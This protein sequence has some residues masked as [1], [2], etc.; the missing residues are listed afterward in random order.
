MLR[1]SNP[2]AVLSTVLLGS[3]VEGWHFVMI[4]VVFTRLVALNLINAIL[5][6]GLLFTAVED[7]QCVKA[8]HSVWEDRERCSLET[9]LNGPW[10]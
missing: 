1:K 2:A 7:R 10:P 8:N 9:L 5:N 4:V 3:A 6:V